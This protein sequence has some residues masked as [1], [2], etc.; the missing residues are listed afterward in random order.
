MTDHM[1]ARDTLPTRTP[2]STFDYPP[3]TPKPPAQPAGPSPLAARIADMYNT[4]DN[5]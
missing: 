5:T 4:R 2:G 1:P 3:P